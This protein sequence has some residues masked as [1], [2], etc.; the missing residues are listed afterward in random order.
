MAKKK[1]IVNRMSIIETLGETTV[2]CSDKTGTITKGEMTTKEL[3]T[4]DRT[5]DI[6]GI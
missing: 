4:Y 6:T 5:L 2:I 3:F 1:A